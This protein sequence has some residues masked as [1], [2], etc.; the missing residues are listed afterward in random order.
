MLEEFRQ[1][2]NNNFESIL[3]KEANKVVE[4]LNNAFGEENV[5][6]T[7]ADQYTKISD[8]FELLIN[9]AFIKEA[10]NHELLLTYDDSDTKLI[11]LDTF[12]L[13]H[14]F[15]TIE[16]LIQCFLE[17]QSF[18]HL[19]SIYNFLITIRF[20][21]VTISNEDYE[22]TKIKNLFVRFVISA[23]GVFKSDGIYMNKT[24]YS[25]AHFLH[26][27]IHSH[28]PA[29]YY[30]DVESFK[31]CCLGSGPINNTLIYLRK[32][33]NEEQW[34]QFC[35]DLE[36]YVT[37]E[38][39]V[40]IPYYK[41]EDCNSIFSKSKI[42]CSNDYYYLSSL[43]SCNSIYVLRKFIPKKDL[44]N[45]IIYLINH[46]V[47]TF[48]WQNDTWIIVE[49][50]I[51]YNIKI[52]KAFF[53]WYKEFYSNDLY[54]LE[55]GFFESMCSEY[56]TSAYLYNNKLYTEDASIESF[57]DYQNT[58]VLT[59]KGKEYYLEIEDPPVEVDTKGLNLLKPRII[60]MIL[61]ILLITLNIHYGK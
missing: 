31:H 2:F 6:I 26:H 43:I 15:F 33:F 49:N 45:F 9:T 10:S 34:M 47:I 42:F 13:E 58:Y 7:K 18:I 57:E 19:L 29:L 53:E 4:I 14:N 38:S 11:E 12:Y 40:G 37:I 25:Y 3:L 54:M 28:T 61:L 39:K 8:L 22:S 35:Y 21:E 23:N 16:D 41:L 27:Y 32:E 36:K 46:K 59:F 20:P 17:S 56:V 30:D 1:W 52:S 5:D 48:T 60:S 51:E 44:L 24:T 55:G 50:P